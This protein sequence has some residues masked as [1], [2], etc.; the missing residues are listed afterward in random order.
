MRVVV[1]K[2]SRGIGFGGLVAA[3]GLAAVA[4]GSAAVGHYGPK[5]YRKIRAEIAKKRARK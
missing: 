3:L 1:W 4:A 2:G 5:V